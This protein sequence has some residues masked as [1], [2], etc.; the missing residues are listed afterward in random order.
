MSNINSP[1]LLWMDCDVG[2]DDAMMLLLALANRELKVLGVSTTYGNSSLAHTTNNTLSFLTAMGF[3]DVPVYVGSARP[4]VPH[5]GKTERA[6]EVHGESGLA[7]TNLLPVPAFSPSSIPA[8]EAM[9]KEFL[10]HPQRSITLVVSG[11]MTNTALLFGSFP[12]TLSKIKEII[13][14]GGSIGIG[15]ATAAAEFN[16]LCDPESA[17]SVFSLPI[18]RGKI[19]LVPLDVTHTVLATNDVLAQLDSSRST[20][21]KMIH[22]LLNYFKS[23]HGKIYAQHEGPPLHDPLTVF[24]MLNPNAFFEK[25]VNVEVELYGNSKGRTLCDMFERSNGPKNVRVTTK[26]DVD[27]FW[28]TMLGA[29]TVIDELASIN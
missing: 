4:F 24:Y 26:V 27:L 8:V 17:Q 16:I 20:F 6:S 5:Q 15:N 22:D 2:H 23:T 7:G 13:V 9:A 21:R 14:M 29:V 18:L 28:Q 10:K 1:K 19:V 12:E 3:T 11:P 25:T